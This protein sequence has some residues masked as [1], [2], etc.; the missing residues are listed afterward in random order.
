MR[1]FFEL[2]DTETQKQITSIEPL[3]T[4]LSQVN[5]EIEKLKKER[6]QLKENLKEIFDEQLKN[7]N[8]CVKKI[9]NNYLKGQVN[10][11]IHPYANVNNL[12]KFLKDGALCASTN[13]R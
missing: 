11:K 7:L 1:D 12:I 5:I 8:K 9:N 13:Y 2:R 6:M 4:Q 3:E 10:I